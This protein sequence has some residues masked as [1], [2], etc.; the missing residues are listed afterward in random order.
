MEIKKR[1]FNERDL[2]VYWGR[3]VRQLQQ[4]RF[5]GKGPPFRKF[6]KSVLYDILAFDRW[7]AEQPGGGDLPEAAA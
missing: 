3:P 7:A 6:G 1:W 5:R 2:S 4:L